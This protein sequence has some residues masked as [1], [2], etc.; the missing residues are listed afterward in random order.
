MG[1]VFRVSTVPETMISPTTLTTT[2]CAIQ[3]MLVLL[4]P[5][6]TK[7]LTQSAAMTTTALQSTILFNKIKTGMVWETLVTIVP[8]SAIPFNKIKMEMVWETL[9]TIALQSAIPFNKIKTEMVWE[10]LVTLFLLPPLL[11][12]HSCLFHIPQPQ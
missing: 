1:N 5:S 2:H 10:T 7:T 6:T 8:H 3:L 9:V 4:I 11:H 12:F